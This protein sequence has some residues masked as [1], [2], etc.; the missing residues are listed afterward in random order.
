M[1]D[2]LFDLIGSQQAAPA[3]LRPLASGHRL[4]GGGVYPGQP[5]LYPLPDQAPLFGITEDKNKKSGG[6]GAAA[7]LAAGAAA[8]AGDPS[9]KN[10][11][12]YHQCY[13]NPISCFK[14]KRAGL[15]K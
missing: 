3:A 12:I 14:R 15:K 8:A 7:G 13:F 4:R 2:Y 5:P 10:K 11:M 6:G 9:G 1:A